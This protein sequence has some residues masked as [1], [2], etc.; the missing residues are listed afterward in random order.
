MV[1]R[2]LLLRFLSSF[3]FISLYFLL[4]YINFKLIF[5]LIILIYFILL[6]EIFFYFIKFKIIP[7]IYIL[8]SFIFFININFNENIILNFNLYVFTVII[9]DTFSYIIGKFFGKNKL[10]N[11]S[12]NKTIEGLIGGILSSFC[13]T[14]LF[15]NIFSIR[16]NMQLLIFISFIIICAFFGDIIESYFKR[17]NELKNSSSFIPGHGGIFD[18]FD[19][20]LSSII[21]YSIF[22]NFTS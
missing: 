6:C 19:S 3:L 14:I 17:K 8:I 9:F 18:R 10:I 7:I 22:I 5:Y 16:I 4:N 2:N 21:F 11:V 12:P 13:L 15:A 1:Y 20:F